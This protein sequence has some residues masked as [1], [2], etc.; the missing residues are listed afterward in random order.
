MIAIEMPARGRA[1]TGSSPEGLPGEDE[2]ARPERRARGPQ[3]R[4]AA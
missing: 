2:R 3:V 4:A 1:R